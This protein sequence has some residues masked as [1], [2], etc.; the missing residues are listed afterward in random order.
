MLLEYNKLLRLVYPDQPTIFTEAQ[1]EQINEIIKYHNYYSGE[2]FKYIV[3]EYP[4][5]GRNSS[6]NTYRPTQITINYIRKIIDKLSS[7]QFETPVDI[8]AED[9]STEDEKGADDIEAY[10]YEWHKRNSMDLKNLQASKE[11]NISGGVA[12][13][14]LPDDELA[15]ARCYIRERIECWPVTEFDDYE[16]INKVHFAAFVDENT[17][18]KQTFSLENG[19]CYI[20]E[21]YYG[22]NLQV[23]EQIIEYSPLKANGVILDFMPVYIVPNLP[24]LGEIWGLSEI[25]DLISLQDEINRKY[26]DLADSL[27]F[28]MFAITILLNVAS[29]SDN[30]EVKTKPGA[31]WQLMGGTA[32]KPPV[33]EKLESRFQYIESLRYHLESMKSLL[34][35]LSDCIQLEGKQI[36]SVGNLSGVAL[37]M[38]FANMISKI[39]QKNT[40]W[41][42]ALERMYMDAAKIKSY[43]DSSFKIPEEL[44]ISIIPHVPVPLNKKEEVDIIVQKLGFNLISI[45]AAMD[46]LGVQNPEALINEILD[47]RKQFDEAMSLYGDSQETKTKQE[48]EDNE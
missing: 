11:H 12:Y 20:E 45:R 28:E 47:E 22:N 13:K 4:E 25:H 7:F 26:S 18:W 16:K 23:Q 27:R 31:I 19:K 46:E 37:R 40:I 21:A 17:I 44:N 15:E 2:S 6:R 9:L 32:D 43:Y 38:L 42:P 30:D 24:T 39:N 35:E 3:E 29:F 8:S 41:T 10:L 1:Q 34:F 14:L 48:K 33:V 5:Y 36:E